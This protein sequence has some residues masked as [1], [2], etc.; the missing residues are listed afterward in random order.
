MPSS[1]EADSLGV[2]GEL[3]TAERKLHSSTVRIDTQSNTSIYDTNR[4]S[5]AP[6]LVKHSFTWA[7]HIISSVPCR[8][9]TSPLLLPEN[10]ILACSA[11]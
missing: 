3:G 8:P 6:P 1:N 11:S 10:T 5:L 7:E 2:G 9:S 4:A